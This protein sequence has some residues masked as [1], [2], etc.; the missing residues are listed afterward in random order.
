MS[1]AATSPRHCLTR[2]PRSRRV[3]RM[4]LERSLSVDGLGGFRRRS[5][6]RRER[7]RS[8]RR[9]LSRPARPPSRNA[10]RQ[11]EPWR[12]GAPLRGA[13]GSAR[14][15]HVL[16]GPRLYRQ[17][18]RSDPR[19]ILRRRAGESDGPFEPPPV[20][21]ARTQ[22]ARRG[23]ARKRDGEGAAVAL[24]SVARGHPQ[25]QALRTVRRAREAVPRKVGHRTRRPGTGCST[26]RSR[27]CA[28][29]STARR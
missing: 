21:P 26:R 13:A 4:G 15:H 28:S 14:A 20:L 24:A 10:R 6:A 17:H 27:R 1:G 7:L 16:C 2:R 3:A 29:T 23:A 18:D 8:L 22:P 25:G 19:E 11:R 12:G 5:R 9:L